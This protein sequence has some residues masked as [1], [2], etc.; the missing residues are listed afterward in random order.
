MPWSAS[1]IP[2]GWEPL[3]QPSAGI[4][5]NTLNQPTL[6]EQEENHLPW[7]HVRDCFLARTSMGRGCRRNRVRGDF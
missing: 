3:H 1:L 4:E 6:Y 7:W 5:P 2:T